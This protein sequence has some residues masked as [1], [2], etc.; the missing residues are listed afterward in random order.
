MRE[1]YKHRFIFTHAPI[2]QPSQAETL[3]SSRMHRFFS[4]DRFQISMLAALF[5]ILA[6]YYL[7]MIYWDILLIHDHSM[8]FLDCLFS[9]RVGS[10]YEVARNNEYYD[11]AASYPLPIYVIFGI[12]DIPIWILRRFGLA[13]SM[14]AGSLLWVKLLL[15]FFLLGSTILLKKLLD[16]LE[17]QEPRFWL[18]MYLSSLLIAL[19][20]MAIVQCDIFSIFFQLLGIYFCV[21]ERKV[22]WKTLVIFSIAISLKYFALFVFVLIVLLMEKR[23][24]LILW[25]MFC[26]VLLSLLSAVPFL[27]NTGYQQIVVTAN[28]GAFDKLLEEALPGGMFDTP[29]FPACLFAAG[30]LAYFWQPVEA[31]DILER[32]SWLAF[33]AYGSFFLFVGFNIYWCILIGPFLICLLS[34]ERIGLKLSLLLEE[35]LEGSLFTF[36]T[37]R[38]SWTL[39]HEDKLSYLLLKNTPVSIAHS[40]AASLETAAANTSSAHA[41]KAAETANAHHQ[42]F[43]QLEAPVSMFHALF[44]VVFGSILLLTYP[45]RPVRED[46]QDTITVTRGGFTLFRVIVL[47]VY[48]IAA[49]MY[50]FINLS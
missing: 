37:Y 48:L 39:F 35:A 10:F 6:F 7:T 24:F 21:K 44:A 11:R 17:C 38:Q 1:R 41:I 20:A 42:L 23:I 34:C 12:W 40:A 14:D 32:L 45:G 47:A 50:C 25:D 36:A 29:L 5:A 22:S 46:P 26:G 2:Y 13:G 30:V 4:S 19:P 43:L 31:I 27:G 3:A 49:L 8:T 16:V 15:V 28:S 9:G 18:F 33:L